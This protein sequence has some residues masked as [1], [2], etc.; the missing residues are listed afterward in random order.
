MRVEEEHKI[1]GGK[2]IDRQ[3]INIRYVDSEKI[4]KKQNN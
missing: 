1:C 3:V 4:V 2:P